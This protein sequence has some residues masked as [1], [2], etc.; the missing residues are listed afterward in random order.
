M[1]EPRARLIDGSKF[2]WDGRA[3]E[4]R[5]EAAS[6]ASEYER[7]RF[8]TRIVEEDDRIRIYTRRVVTADG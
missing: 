8:E 3:Y 4:S 2:M 7:E 5:D 1:A 6:A